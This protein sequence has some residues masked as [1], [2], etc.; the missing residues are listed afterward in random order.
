MPSIEGDCI[1][2]HDDTFGLT[3]PL[4]KSHASEHGSIFLS[5]YTNVLALKL[6][7][8]QQEPNHLHFPIFHCQDSTKLSNAAMVYQLSIKETLH[9]QTHLRNQKKR[10]GSYSPPPYIA[11]SYA[12]DLKP[13]NPAPLLPTP[14][15]RR[16]PVN[17]NHAL[18]QTPPKPKKH[19][20]I[21]IPY[22]LRFSIHTPHRSYKHPLFNQHTY[23]TTH[24]TRPKK[25]KKNLQK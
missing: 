11:T 13:F 8:H 22:I 5:Y 23:P 19:S 15:Q 12:D 21:S 3:F 24:K 10:I 25:P 14:Q 6:G 17:Q 20:N 4:H 18:Q 9:Y 7:F 16:Y 2:A 1:M